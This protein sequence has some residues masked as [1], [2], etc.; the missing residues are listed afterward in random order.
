MNKIDFQYERLLT[1]GWMI[2]ASSQVSRTPE[3]ISTAGFDTR[4]WYPAN[5]PSTVL[6]T[7]VETESMRILISA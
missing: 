4:R 6:A 5:V 3:R 2:Q 7:L 1:A